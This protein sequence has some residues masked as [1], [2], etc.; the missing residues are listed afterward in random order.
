MDRMQKVK[1]DKGLKPFYDGPQLHHIC[2]QRGAVSL[3]SLCLSTTWAFFMSVLVRIGAVSSNNIG[4]SIGG[5][6][7]KGK[8][9]GLKLPLSPFCF[10]GVIYIECYS[11]TSV[12][13]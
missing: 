6:Y 2:I 5:R 10:A 4:G 1:P 11:V 3:K 13:R 8:S 7:R 12:T 9:C